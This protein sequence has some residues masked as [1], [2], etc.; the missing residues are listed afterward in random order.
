MT[1]AVPL[2]ELL[3]ALVGYPWGYLVT[4]GDDAGAR[5]HAAP[6]RYEDGV[7]VVDAGAR[8]RANASA[9]TNVT[10]VFPPTEPAA[11]SL[12]V[13]GDATVEPDA[14]RI[15]PTWAVLHRAAI[16]PADAAPDAGHAT[17]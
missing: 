16:G 6:T 15:R 4:V 13:D 8:S 12:I 9:R 7:F 5:L 2:D 1:I 14:V 10:L 17:G 3:A 11:M